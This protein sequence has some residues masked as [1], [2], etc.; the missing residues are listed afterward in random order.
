[1]VNKKESVLANTSALFV[2]TELLRERFGK[3]VHHSRPCPSPPIL[4]CAS[5]Q[6]C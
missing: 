5:L 2:E 4:A 3:R 1:M 6:E